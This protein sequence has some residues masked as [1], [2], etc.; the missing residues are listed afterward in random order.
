M[1]FCS[2]PWFLAGFFVRV[3]RRALNKSQIQM[4]AI[5]FY[6]MIADEEICKIDLSAQ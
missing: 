5:G 3:R 4:H 6:E 1:R 2:W